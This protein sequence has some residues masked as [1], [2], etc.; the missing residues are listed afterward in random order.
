MGLINDN[1]L[2]LLWQWG[3]RPTMGVDIVIFVFFC[4]FYAFRLNVDIFLPYSHS[5]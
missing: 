2:W 3:D 5:V 1:G 4:I